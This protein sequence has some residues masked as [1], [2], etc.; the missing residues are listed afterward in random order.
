MTPIALKP[1]V[2]RL[3]A[4]VPFTGHP[5]RIPGRFE[6]FG[7]GCTTTQA[8][9]SGLIAIEPSE[10]RDARGVTF[11]RV[12]ELTEAQ[13]IFGQSVQVGCFNFGSVAT[14]IGKPQVIR[15]NEDDVGTLGLAGQ[16]GAK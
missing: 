8:T 16:N 1:E 4:Q 7:N 5:G 3:F 6:N 15:H 11:G 13:T 14:K 2:R 12:V 9:G 10:E